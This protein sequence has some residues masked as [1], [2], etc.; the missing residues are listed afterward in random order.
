[1]TSKT[2]NAI[3]T[4]TRRSVQDIGEGRRRDL[5]RKR[6]TPKDNVD[7]TRI[8]ELLDNL[9]LE[10]VVRNAIVKRDGNEIGEIDAIFSFNGNLILVEVKKRKKLDSNLVIAFF[11]KWSVQKNLI[12]V[13]RKYGTSRQ[14]IIRIF[15]DASNE[16][17]EKQSTLSPFLN[18]TNHIIYRDEVETIEDNYRLVG[19][20]ELNNLLA[21]LRIKRKRP[22]RTTVPAVVLYIRDRPVFLFSLPSDELLECC[23]ITRRYKHDPGYQRAIKKSRIRKMRKGIRNKS[24]IAFPNSI[25]VNSSI[26]LLKPLPMPNDCPKAIELTVPLIY[27]FL[28]VVDG[29]HRLLSFT[30]LPKSIQQAHDL[31]V[32]A[33]EQLKPDEEAEIFVEINTTQKRVDANLVLILKADYATPDHKDWYDKVAVDVAKNLDRN[34][35]LAG[36]IYFGYADQDSSDK[37][38]RL[39][40]LVSAMKAHGFVGRNAL[41]QMNKTDIKSPTTKIRRML[42]LLKK[43]KMFSAKNR[44]FISS[45]GIRVIFR[46]VHLFERNKQAGNIVLSFEKAMSYLGVIMDDDLLERIAS[47]YGEGGA[48]RAT[49]EIVD[50]LSSK[51]PKF[52]D[53]ETDLRYI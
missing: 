47:Y 41:F 19:K 35:E 23:H 32:L 21:K 33:F 51:Y 25:L 43:E 6:K 7:E 29:Q 22:K 10:L 48:T 8:V 44:F 18:D 50:E 46:F 53:F 4:S 49:E 15:F 12:D 3:S 40:T 24:I 16:R 52:E 17:P 5:P 27:S 2:T 13:K 31:T 30:E 20:W 26:P 37:W 1:M 39:R 38:V 36:R 28:K 34:S 9:G 42:R 14:K 45:M 11:K